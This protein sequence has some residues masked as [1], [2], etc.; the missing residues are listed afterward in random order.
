MIGELTEA[1]KQ[2]KHKIILA[3]KKHFSLVGFT[4]AEMDK[5]ASDA[6][7]GKGTLYRYFKNKED[8]YLH[9]VEHMLEIF[10][11]SVYK[12]TEKIENPVEFLL[13][14]I[15]SSIDHH[16]RYR[17]GYDLVIRS[18]ASLLDSVIDLLSKM[19]KDYYAK[20]D[21]IIT[22]AIRD[23][24]FRP[25]KTDIILKI[26]DASGAYLLHEHL[27]RG[28][29]DREEISECLKAILL[30]GLVINGNVAR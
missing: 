7:V 5:I 16:C 19:Q 9:A 11:D 18:G 15:E 3:A 17:E 25:F 30:N 8:L 10:F 27:K 12:A 4:E 23:G 2:R 26:F 29:Y 22:K 1:Q 24:I 14:Y 20:F 6:G 28:K 13:T 21:R